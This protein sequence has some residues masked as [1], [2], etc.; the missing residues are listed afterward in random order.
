[1]EDN[2][3]DQEK[4]PENLLPTIN[5][6]LGENH[7][8][9]QPTVDHFVNT[10]F[11]EYHQTKGGNATGTINVMEDIS[12]TKVNNE[13]SI[14]AWKIGAIFTAVVLVLETVF[15]IIYVVKC[16][17]KESPLA[18]QQAGVKGCV[19]PEAGMGGNC[20]EDTPSADNG[21][22]L[23]MARLD[24]CGVATTL[25]RKREKQ[26]DEHEVTVSN[27]LPSSEEMLPSPESGQDFPT[28]I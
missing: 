19:D 5:P 17:N 2:T 3:K 9:I 13:H 14:Q 28:P 8:E 21:K 25:A 10:A 7:G 4:R 20:S 26:E 24:P 6:S 18:M 11:A 12:R 27:Q 16:R 15:F 22:C 23:E 1:M